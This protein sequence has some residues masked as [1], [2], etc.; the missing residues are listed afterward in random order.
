MAISSIR[1][2]HE[3]TAKVLQFFIMILLL[4]NL[5]T[6][7]GRLPRLVCWRENF[8]VSILTTLSLSLVGYCVIIG[9]QLHTI[10]IY[11]TLLHCVLYI[12][13]CSFM[14]MYVCMYMYVH[15]YIPYCF[16]WK[17]DSNTNQSRLDA[18]G[19][20]AAI[21]RSR[22]SNISQGGAYVLRPPPATYTYLNGYKRTRMVY[23]VSFKLKAVDYICDGLS[24]RFPARSKLDALPG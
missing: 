22:V 5:I 4:H 21:N 23:A 2:A 13:V 19:V 17:P 18:G 1:S 10:G 8:E 9:H 14:Y 24:Q 7:E 16:E 3:K 20:C 11:V 15:V 6:Q 12:Y